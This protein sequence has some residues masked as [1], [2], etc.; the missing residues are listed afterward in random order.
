MKV[1]AINGSPRKGWNT[2]T[3]Q[4]KDYSRYHLGRFGAEAKRL[5]HETVFPQD[6]QKAFELGV[7]LGQKN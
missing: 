4:A 3:L 2:D 1:L 7:R 6:C 5:R